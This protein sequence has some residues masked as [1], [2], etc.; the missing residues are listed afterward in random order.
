[1]ASSENMLVSLGLDPLLADRQFSR[2]LSTGILATHSGHR[3]VCCGPEM[4]RSLQ[5]IL[6]RERPGAWA[7]TLKAAGHFCGKNFAAN[8]DTSL[9]ALG[10]PMLSG[11]PLD[12]CLVFIESFFAREGLGVLKLDLSPA[13]EHGL[14]VARMQNSFFAEVTLEQGAFADAMPA[15]LLQGFFAHISGQGLG[16]DEIACVAQG[17]PQCTFV[18]TAPER[19]SAVHPLLGRAPAE[20]IIQQ[21]CT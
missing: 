21:L 5:L 8:L 15:G 9:G 3:S 20:A 7:A 18:L 17:A 16:C 12:V 10:K 14:I 2:N 6:G 1:M 19:L 13:S 4:M 11:L